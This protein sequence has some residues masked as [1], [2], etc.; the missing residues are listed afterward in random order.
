MHSPVTSAPSSD[1]HASTK[2]CQLADGIG[3]TGRGG[4]RGARGGDGG[5][6]GGE[7][8]EGGGEGATQVILIALHELA[9]PVTALVHVN[10]A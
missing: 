9:G 3:V 6:G 1:K 7:G 4:E 2:S 8:G 5:E 10:F